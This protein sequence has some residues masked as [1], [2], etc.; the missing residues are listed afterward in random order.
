VALGERAGVSAS[1]NERGPDGH[2]SRSLGRGPPALSVLWDVGRPRAR[3]GVRPY[4]PHSRIELATKWY[5]FCAPP[6]S[7]TTG[8]D[9]C[10]GEASRLSGIRLK[11]FHR[12]GRRDGTDKTTQVGLD[13]FCVGS[14]AMYAKGEGVAGVTAWAAHLRS[15]DVPGTKRRVAATTDWM[16]STRYGRCLSLSARRSACAPPRRGRSWSVLAD[17]SP[18]RQTVANLVRNSES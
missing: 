15:P 16:R 12:P 17:E 8:S 11:C 13:R 9:S 5:A 3:H 7:S 14:S 4:P 1:P 18:A 6:S 10:S 2:R